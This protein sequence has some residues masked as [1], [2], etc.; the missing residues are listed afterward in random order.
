MQLLLSPTTSAA[1]PSLT[2]TTAP[3]S[4]PP[5][6]VSSARFKAPPSWHCCAMADEHLEGGF[7]RGWRCA[8]DGEREI[9][10]G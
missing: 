10:T 6:A 1:V 3:P 9:A 8:T 4:T 7:S 5:A 2:T